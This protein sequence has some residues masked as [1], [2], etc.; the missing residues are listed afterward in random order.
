MHQSV[1][2]PR[3]YC[4]WFMRGSLQ[5]FI[6]AKVAEVDEI[7]LLDEYATQVAE[8]FGYKLLG[9]AFAKNKYLEP[10]SQLGYSV[11][12]VIQDSDGTRYLASIDGAGLI[13]LLPET[14]EKISI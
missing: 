11:L 12:N 1:P 13:K 7:N 6:D 9:W 5:I 8:I 4:K 10:L 2:I 3:Q 14:F